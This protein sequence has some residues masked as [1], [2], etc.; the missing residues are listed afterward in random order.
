[1]AWSLP[2]GRFNLQA[3]GYD[4]LAKCD[5][6]LVKLNIKML[7]NAHP[8]AIWYNLDGKEN[9][10]LPI[11]LIGWTY[12]STED[13]VAMYQGW[14]LST[15]SIPLIAHYP[16]HRNYCWRKEKTHPSTQGSGRNVSRLMPITLMIVLIAA[17]PSH[18]AV[19]A[20]RDGYSSHTTP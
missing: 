14:L 3:P 1:M 20:A 7:W 5:R 8:I 13:L 11:I 19:N 6:E 12:P 15:F 2:A 4:L 16:T 17:M 9:G 10:T 18:P